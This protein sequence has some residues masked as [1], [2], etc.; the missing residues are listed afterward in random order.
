MIIQKFLTYMNKC[1]WNI[2]MKK[3]RGFNLPETIKKRYKH[4][5]EIW[6][7]FI[8]VVQSMVSGDETTWFLCEDDYDLQGTRAFHWNEWELVS[9]E[10]AE[11][12]EEWE[13]E[14]KE[15]W[16]KNFPIILSVKNGYSYYAISMEN[17]SIVKGS[18]PEFEECEKVADSFEDFMKSIF[19]GF[20][21]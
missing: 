9:L 16:D 13:N 4:I 14:I 18:E 5:P 7:E 11:N 12:D 19:E 17:G 3:E 21:L 10:N 15:F 1:G 20:I 2:E 8:A 6:F